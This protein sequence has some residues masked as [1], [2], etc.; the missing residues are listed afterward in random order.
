MNPDVCALYGPLIGLA[1][2]A[3]KRIPFVRRFPK[4][5]ATICAAVIAAAP[6]VLEGRPADLATLVRCTLEQLAGAVLTF[7]AGI[8][9]A[10]KK[11]RGT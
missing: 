7:E 8:K 6:I 2:S 4:V 9:P 1:V 3:A 5:V 10:R 11:L